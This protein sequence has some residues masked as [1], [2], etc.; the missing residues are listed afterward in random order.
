MQAWA[1]T[2]PGL[3][4][5]SD[6]LAL[7]KSSKA[8]KMLKMQIDPAM[9][10]KTM[11]AHDK[12]PGVFQN[13]ADILCKCAG[14][15]GSKSE[16]QGENR[17]QAPGCH[18]SPAPVFG[19]GGEGPGDPGNNLGGLQCAE[20]GNEGISPEDAENKRTA[21]RF[22]LSAPGSA[23]KTGRDALEGQPVTVRG[24]AFDDSI[25]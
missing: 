12:T 19:A 1:N 13:L 23:Q 7:R 6:N 5:P 22:R 11:G 24:R 20:A 4:P 17:S 15:S 2:A 9:C 10:M 25:K 21:L 3:I 8:I 16:K 18:F 14:F